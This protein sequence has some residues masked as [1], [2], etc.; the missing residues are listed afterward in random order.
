MDVYAI[1]TEKIIVTPLESGV[2][3][4]RRRGSTGLPGNLI[5]W[6]PYRGI[7]YFLLSASKYVSRSGSRCARPTRLA[8]RSAR[9]R[10]EPRSLPFWKIDDAKQSD[11][12]EPDATS[13]DEKSCRRFVPAFY[14]VWNLEQC[15]LPQPSVTLVVLAEIAPSSA[16]DFDTLNWPT[17]ML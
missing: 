1:V 4:W 9:A 15:D 14:W 2:V 10:G 3:P 6:K 16:S 7:N 11:T 13:K 8:D 12:E 5:H 17:S